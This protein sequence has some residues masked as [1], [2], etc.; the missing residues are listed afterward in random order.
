MSGV[1]VAGV[2]LGAIPLVIEAFDHCGR[3]YDAFATYK[4]YPREIMKIDSKLGAQRTVFRNSCINL[5]A[6][7][8]D[9][10]QRVLDMVTQPSHEMWKDQRR[11]NEM[12]SLQTG[13]L[14][15]TFHSCNRTMEQIHVALQ[16]INR[17][18]EGIRSLLRETPTVRMAENPLN[19]QV[20][21]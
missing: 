16:A 3:A 19:S 9:D 7:L 18:T 20:I 11:L 21:C 5:L 2:I 8:T 4:E 13:S 14:D 10:R 12:F 6:S 15:Q 1:E 17:E